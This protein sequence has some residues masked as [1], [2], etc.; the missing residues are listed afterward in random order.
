[1]E[2]NRVTAASVHLLEILVA[3]ARLATKTRAGAIST[4]LMLNA[5]MMAYVVAAPKR[6]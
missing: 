2:L 3:W 4:P 1:M 5:A 6:V